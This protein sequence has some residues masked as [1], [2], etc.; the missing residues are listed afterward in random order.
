MYGYKFIQGCI[1]ST[2]TM[3]MKQQNWIPTLTSLSN[4]ALV[5]VPTDKSPKVPQLREFS[6][7][8]KYWVKTK[9]AIDPFVTSTCVNFDFSKNCKVDFLVCQKCLFLLI[10]MR[11]SY[12][13]E[14]KW[15]H[16]TARLTQEWCIIDHEQRRF[17]CEL[18]FSPKLHQ[19]F[20]NNGLMQ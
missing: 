10:L 8:S 15:G 20:E 1:D 4:V 2:S 11:I 5:I 17:W 12:E 13:I 18:H 16:G 7:K 3:W 9:D 6:R 14:A 19:G